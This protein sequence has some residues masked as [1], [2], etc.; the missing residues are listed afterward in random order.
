VRELAGIKG[1]AREP[2]KPW[3]ADAAARVKL[4]A[5]LADL[6]TRAI[7]ALSGPVASSEPALQPPPPSKP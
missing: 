6:N 5:A 7:Q 2:L 4:E 3:L 1:P